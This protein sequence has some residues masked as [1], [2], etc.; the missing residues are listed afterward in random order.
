MLSK[1]VNAIFNS[2]DL[3]ID[4]FNVRYQSI[5]IEMILRKY[6]KMSEQNAPSV[7]CINLKYSNYQLN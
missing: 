7:H 1:S 5:S 4:G 2:F 3:K 6:L